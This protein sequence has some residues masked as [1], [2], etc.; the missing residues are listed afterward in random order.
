ML[1]TVFGKSDKH[2]ITRACCDLTS[3]AHVCTEWIKSFWI[4]V[5]VL[6]RRLTSDRFPDP[7][8]PAV[9]DDSRKIWVELFVVMA[10]KI[11]I[12]MIGNI[13]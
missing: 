6:K 11:R 5:A 8:F 3:R 9:V 12:S 13:R 10:I 1:F 7:F 2:A 4:V